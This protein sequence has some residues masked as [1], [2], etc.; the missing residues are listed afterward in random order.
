KLEELKFIDNNMKKL[1]EELYEFNFKIEKL[2]KSKEEQED[3]IRKLY[4]LISKNKPVEK[5]NEQNLNHK[6]EIREEIKKEKMMFEKKE[7][8][9]NECE[10]I[11]DNLEEVEIFLTESEEIEAEMYIKILLQYKNS[12]KRQ[13]DKIKIS[14]IDEDEYSEDLT[15]KIC[16]II[17]RDFIRLLQSALK[18]EK[19]KKTLFYKQLREK[20]E[21]YLYS[22]NFYKKELKIEENQ[23]L[24]EDCYTYMN[25]SKVSTEDKQLNKK[26]K[27]I[28]LMPY[29]LKFKNED[30]AV[31]EYVTKGKAIVY[32]VKE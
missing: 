28:E 18:G 32:I 22:L 27:E 23:D 10:I 11:I 16:N 21:N 29:F 19:I 31:E 14:T 13:I 5:K 26:I 7:N 3:V 25:L 15:Y 20:F 4:E 8:F 24:T 6:I 12:I 30:E 1:K 9:D 2:E 17:E